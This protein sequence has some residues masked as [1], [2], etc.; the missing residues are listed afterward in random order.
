MSGLLTAVI[1][2][3]M[4]AVILSLQAWQNPQRLAREFAAHLNEGNS[5]AWFYLATEAREKVSW[6]DAPAIHRLVA[7]FQSGAFQEPEAGNSFFYRTVDVTV[8]QDADEVPLR[9]YF[10]RTLAGW[11]ITYI[12]AAGG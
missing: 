1:L 10:T 6:F 9:L 3:M 7:A 4:A 11:R 12:K 8:V 5:R 2:L